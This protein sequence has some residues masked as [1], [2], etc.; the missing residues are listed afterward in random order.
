MND[1]LSDEKSSPGKGEKDSPRC[2][3]EGRDECT[4]KRNI[5]ETEGIKF[6][7]R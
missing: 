3:F 7:R 2:M 1:V 6:Q 4:L 5:L